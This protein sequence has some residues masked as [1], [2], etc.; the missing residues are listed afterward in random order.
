MWTLTTSDSVLHDDGFS[1]KFVAKVLPVALETKTIPPL[2]AR[3]RAIYDL[4]APPT[5]R[6]G[7]KDCGLLDRLVEK[8]TSPLPPD[9][10]D[11]LKEKLWTLRGELRFLDF[12]SGMNCE[13]ERAH[14]AGLIDAEKTS[15]RLDAE[16]KRVVL[17]IQALERQLRGTK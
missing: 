1:M 7:C 4:A 2:L 10:L 8:L 16:R 17:E 15:A 14:R 9:D 3:A 12:E 6:A 13:E 5:G 11:R